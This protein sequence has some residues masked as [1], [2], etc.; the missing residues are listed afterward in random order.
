MGTLALDSLSTEP[1]SALEVFCG[2]VVFCPAGV[3][4]KDGIATA[5][6]AMMIATAAARRISTILFAMNSRQVVRIKEISPIVQD[7]LQLFDPFARVSL[8]L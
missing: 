4:V 2:V 8:Q 1:G 6:P 5:V 3:C 7:P